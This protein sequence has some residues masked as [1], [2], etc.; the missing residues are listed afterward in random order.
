MPLVRLTSSAQRSPAASQALLRS[1]SRL[2]ADRLG[3][4]EDYVMTCFVPASMTFAGT[5]EPCAFLELKS[6][7][8][9]SP[10]QTRDLS[11]VL[12]P[13]VGEALGLPPS[14]VYIEFQDAKG[15][16]WGHDSDTFG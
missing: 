8:R 4:P 3:K 13:L 2:V 5:D 6:I 11:K 9:F 10:Q 7:G 1:L 14:R 16:L 12:C 15:D